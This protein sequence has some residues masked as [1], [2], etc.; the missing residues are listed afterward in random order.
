MKPISTFVKLT[1]TVLLFFSFAIL[2]ITMMGMIFG[3]I[4]KAIKTL[5]GAG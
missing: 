4:V 3:P 2:I 1:M 5:G